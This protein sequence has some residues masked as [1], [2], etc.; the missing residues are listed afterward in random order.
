[1][2]H[3]FRF[4][5]VLRRTGPAAL[6]LAA[7]ALLAAC[8][9]YYGPHPIPEGYANHNKLY[10][11]PDAARPHSIGYPYSEQA[12]AESAVYWQMAAGE[13]VGRLVQGGAVPPRLV[14][15]E[16]PRP[17]TP[18]DASFDHALREEL[19]KNH[20]N[21]LSSLEG[22]GEVPVIRYTVAVVQPESPSGSGE[23]D[24]MSG[25]EPQV[26]MDL[27]VTTGQNVLARESGVYPV[28]EAADYTYRAPLVD[29][30]PIVGE[31]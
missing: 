3:S 15:I 17:R 23:D 16:P 8:Q 25:S 1:M 6:W 4:L 24:G 2:L 21:L 27:T 7:T 9:G 29:M 19:L 5:P 22:A 13:L 30:K 26:K 31:Y 18:L 28:P 12:N 10:K 11:S 20:Y 14:Y